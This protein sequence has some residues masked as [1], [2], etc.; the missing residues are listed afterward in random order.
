MATRLKSIEPA[1]GALVWQVETGDTDREVA[2]ARAAW[3]DWAHQPLPNRIELVRRFANI[4]KNRI[5]SIATLV[6]R[7]TGKPLWDATAEIARAIE[8]VH[9]A[10]NAHSERTPHRQSENDLGNRRA[11]RHKP[12][13]VLALITPFSSPI[14]MPANHIAAALLAGNT[15]VFKPSEKATASGRVL[16]D[17]LH[18][19]GIPEGAIRLLVGAAEEGQAL[20]HHPQIDGLIFGGTARVG[21]FLHRQFAPTP[22]RILALAMGGNNPLVVWQS[23]DL[24]AAAQ[25]VLQSAF[26]SAGQRCTS[27]RRLIV[28]D[29]VQQPLIDI[30]LSMIDRMIIAEPNSAPDPFMGPLI[31]N[32]AAR[33]I[34]ADFLDLMMKGGHPIRH[35]TRPI[36]DRPFITPGLIDMTEAGERP[37]RE[38][39]GPI[40][41]M[42]RVS[43]FDAAI[44]EANATRFGL[45]AAL[46]S[47][48]HALYDQFWNQI[49]AG[50]INWN[51][52]TTD[53]PAG[54][55]FG[56]V[57][58]SGNHRP[59]GSYA[60]DICAYPV[61]S[62]ETEYL[63]RNI[64]FG[65]R[66]P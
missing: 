10:I 24:Q 56:G 3:P 31:D 22:H 62:M 20:V 17:C 33:A 45:V 58:Q 19:A 34:Q 32:E 30:I 61:L 18:A 50:A 2:M 63:R 36:P 53:I 7:E 5:G 16:V 4:L 9:I 28:E 54:T 15:I 27:A 35:P 43:S 26:L 29:G 23:A 55:P 38:I 13:G 47:D 39:F 46:V 48:S 12:H 14:S 52:P 21:G 6:A 40:L 41:Q 37:D 60:A 64:D 8:S 49:R 57:G 11:V 42:I 59:G 44:A 51:H 25:I 65:L 1:S 66:E